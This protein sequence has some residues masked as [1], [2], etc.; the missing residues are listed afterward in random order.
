[1]IDS[2]GSATGRA[3][4]SPV[5]RRALVVTGAVMAATVAWVLAQLTGTILEVEM[6]GRSPLTV[7]LPEVLIVA[8]VA[9]LAGWG[10]VELLH[11]LTRRAAAAWTVLSLAVLLASLLPIILADISAGVGAYLAAMHLAVGAVLI[12]GLRATLPTVTERSA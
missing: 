2:T 4:T 8:V 11:R 9:S 12:P 10:A 7:G 3:G 1:M 5:F 6:A